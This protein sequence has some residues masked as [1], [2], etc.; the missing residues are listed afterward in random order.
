MSPVE[1]G[2]TNALA[3]DDAPRFRHTF[4]VSIHRVDGVA[5]CRIF[6]YYSRWAL[7]RPTTARLVQPILSVPGVNTIIDKKDEFGYRVLDSTG[8]PVVVLDLEG[9]IVLF[10]PASEALS[11]YRYA[12]LQG[13]YFWEMLPVP[14]EA[15]CMRE[16]GIQ[17]LA[18]AL[19]QGTVRR[20]FCWQDNN[21]ANHF[22]EW[23]ITPMLASDGKVEYIVFTGLDETDHHR[24]EA[25][26]QKSERKFHQLA[27]QAPIMIGT[28][29]ETGHITFLNKTWLD[30][31]GKTIEEEEGWAWAA[32]LH[33]EDRQRTLSEMESCISQLKPYSIEYRIEDCDGKYHWL[34]D[35]AVPRVD[36]EGKPRGYIGTAINIT[37]RKE[38]ELALADSEE[39]Y[40]DIV[41]TSQEGICTIDAESRTTFANPRM[42]KMLGYDIDEMLGKSIFEF[43][44]EQGRVWAEEEILERRQTGTKE[45]YVFR[46][47]HRNGNVVWVQVSATPLLNAQGSFVGTLAMMTDI[48][49]RKRTEEKLAQV[50]RMLEQANDVANMGAW[51]FNPGSKELFWSDITRRIHEVDPD[52]QPELETAIN[53]YRQGEYRDTIKRVVENAIERGEPWDEELIIVTAKGNEK[54]VK[55]IGQA[56]FSGNTCQRLY[57]SFQDITARKLAE[58]EFERIFELSLDII[59]TGNL[60]GYFTRVN[61]SARKMLGYDAE[62]FCAKPFV[63][64][65]YKDD[66]EKTIAKLQAAQKGEKNLYIENR[67]VCKDGSIKWIA[68]NVLALADENKFYAT[69]RDF[70]DRRLIEEALRE[71][72][73]WMKNIFNSLREAVLVV[74]PDRRLINVNQA[75]LDIFGYSREEIMSSSTELFHVDH[76]HYLEFGEIISKA[77]AENK[78]ANFEFRAKRKNGDIFPS[79][80][81]VSL[82]KDEDGKVIGIVSVVRDIT[83]RRNARD[84]LE[85]HRANLEERVAERTLELRN[86]QDELVRKERLATLGQLTATVSHELRNPL[87][88]M[89]PSIYIVK[90]YLGDSADEKLVN[91]IERIDRNITRCD[92]I[93]DELLDFTRITDLHK[94]ETL[95]DQW[96]DSVIDDCIELPGVTIQK[97]Y[98]LEGV[99]VPV[100]T[101]RL[102]RAI[103]NVIDNAHQAMRGSEPG[104]GEIPEPVLTIATR[105][106]GGRVEISVS[107]TGPGIPDDVLPRIFEPLF[108]TRNF[109]VGLGMPTVRQIMMQHGGGVD[110]STREGEGTTVTLW[111]PAGDPGL[112]G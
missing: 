45:L 24:S 16:S 96:L 67:Y 27:D 87:G 73:L 60:Q 91:A 51:E 5:C 36:A 88:S 107:D 18:Q 112:T 4:R 93:I 38:A 62:E 56:D 43:M 63:E 10:N 37:A 89:R 29:D 22:V 74:S 13:Q 42:A 86:A 106:G 15:D 105:A 48:T 3:S 44:D 61:S 94:S 55:A 104:S 8:A 30:F 20:T 52:Y 23:V 85:R 39:R 17:L 102:Q 32:G 72:E 108:S 2:P 41:E 95:I 49:E 68:W 11:G 103:I 59:G 97:K 14:E 21:G 78:T 66:V 47:R 33:P 46:L 100:D 28:T 53:F 101:N 12:D 54:W 90:K 109:G 57:G 9:R 26:L 75:A 99:G 58:Q 82:L 92:H 35:T 69:G 34:L 6:P 80:H 110:I 50:Q 111:L 64:F 76:R 83:E 31:R 7:L 25:A 98:S 81:T 19:R 79:E 84:E 77:F 40:R 70:T 65:V 1:F 71:S